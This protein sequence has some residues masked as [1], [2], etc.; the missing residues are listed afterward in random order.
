MGSTTATTTFAT[1]PTPQHFNDADFESPAKILQK[2]KRATSIMT[3]SIPGTPPVMDDDATSDDETISNVRTPTTIVSDEREEQQV[4]DSTA[5]LSTTSGRLSSQF[6]FK[7]PV[8]NNKYKQ[9]HFHRPAKRSGL[10]HGLKRFFKKEN[11]SSVSSNGSIRS[12]T[13]SSGRSLSFANAFNKDIEARYGKW[14]TFYIA[15][16]NNA[17]RSRHVARLLTEILSFM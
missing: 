8:Y 5:D 12:S 4:V 11:T 7:K 6:K 14:G 17:A 9:T 13:S 10:L 3:L 16:I 2:K 15:R 1:L